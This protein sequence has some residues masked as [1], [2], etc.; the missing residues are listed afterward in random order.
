MCL[1]MSQNESEQHK[2]I[3]DTIKREISRFIIQNLNTVNVTEQNKIDITS[4]LKI[5][6]S[7]MYY[8]NLHL[9]HELLNSIPV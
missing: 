3:E 7:K 2:T 1:S 8:N 4:Y 9:I 6:Q 5:I